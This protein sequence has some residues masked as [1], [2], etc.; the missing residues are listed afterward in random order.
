MAFN[1]TFLLDCIF[2]RLM[3]DIKDSG[4]SREN[5]VRFV[6]W[7]EVMNNDLKVRVQGIVGQTFSSSVGVWF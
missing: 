3:K 6:M 5:G 7:Q 1:S 2:F 4:M